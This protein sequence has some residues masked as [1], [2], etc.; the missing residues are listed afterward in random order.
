[1]YISNFPVQTAKP[2]ADCKFQDGDFQY[3]H[4]NSGW[5]WWSGT[6]FAAPIVS[7]FLT[8]WWGFNPAQTKNQA[9]AVLNGLTNT[10]DNG[11]KVLLIT[12][13]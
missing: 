13:Q 6:S 1:V 5:A 9:T 2:S 12:Q 10:G 7:G 8:A 11:E 3:Q 4:N